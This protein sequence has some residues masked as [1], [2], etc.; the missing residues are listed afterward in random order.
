MV[1]EMKADPSIRKVLG[2]PYALNPK[3]VRG[4]DGS[5]QAGVRFDKDFN[6][7]T[8]PFVMAAINSRVV[9]RSHALMGLP[10]G[11]GF[12]YSE[13]MS[14]GKGPKGLMRAFAIAA[15]VAGGFGLIAMPL[16]RPFVEKRLPAPGEGPSK[17]QRENGF[18]KVRLMALGSG[19]KVRGLVEG[20]QDPGYGAT[21]IMLG[22]SALCL[23]LDSDKIHRDGSVMTPAF[24][25]GNVLIE[26]LRNAG[27]TFR[28]EA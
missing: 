6:M 7:W 18:F 3:G 17:E 14:T 2:N 11:E 9:R 23:A 4:P 1:D 20:F 15:G 19:N 16:T 13:F 26:R 24:A 8:A 25:M 22:E 28:V 21:A 10:W 5:D 27:M 12:R